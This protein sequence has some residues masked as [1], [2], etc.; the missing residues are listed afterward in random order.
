MRNI[1]NPR[2][3]AARSLDVFVPLILSLGLL[4][5]AAAQTEIPAGADLWQ[6]VG[7]GG[8]TFQDF[9][10]SPIPADF[11]GDGSEA[12]DGT[13]ELIGLP[14]AENPGL[15]PE[16]VDLG[17]ADT[18]VERL[19][20]VV[21]DS[22]GG[23]GATTIQIAALSLHSIEPITVNVNGEPTQWNVEVQLSNQ[24]QQQG[25][26]TITLEDEF[27]GTFNSNLPVLPMFIFVNN[28]NPSD[29]KI[30][31][32]G[33]D[34]GEPIMFLTINGHWLING[35][36][37][38][39]L[40]QPTSTINLVNGVSVPPPV[41]FFPGLALNPFGS[42]KWVLTTEEAQLAQHGVF[43]ARFM[44][45]EDFDGDGI[46]DDCDN[47]PI[48]ANPLQEDEDDDCIGDACDNCPT[49]ANFD[50]ADLDADG[51]GSVCD[52]E[53]LDPNSS[54]PAGSD[55]WSTPDG[56]QTF[57]DF[58]DNPIPADFFGEGSEPF[59]GIIELG[60]SPL[61]ATNLGTGDTVVER[62][63]DATL[64]GP[65]SSDTVPIEM[66]ALSLVSINPITVVIDGEDTQWDVAVSLSDQPQQQGTITIN[67]VDEHGGTFDA[68]LP[69]LPRFTFTRNGS[70]PV[71]LDLGDQDPIVLITQNG[72]F[73]FDNLNCETVGLD[74]ALTLP[75]GT[76]IEGTTDN[77]H[78]SLTLD[79]VGQCKWV[80]TTEEAQLAR[81]GVFPARFQI[82]T[83]ED[84]DSIA[85]DC[86]NCPKVA[87]PLQ[88][89]EDE[90]CVGDACDNC[91]DVYN[92][93]QANADGDVEGDACDNCPNDPDKTSPGVCGC[94]VADDDTDGD[95]TEDCN[96]ECPDDPDKT[97]EGDCGCGESD[98]DTD[99][100]TIADCR[101]NCPDTANTDQADDDGDGEGNACEPDTGGDGP[102]FCFPNAS[103][104]TLLTVALMAGLALIQRRRYR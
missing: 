90:D 52:D 17:L 35:S 57:Q 5:S 77:F 8:Q 32:L 4:S 55:L 11:F 18:L 69:V 67:Q 58:A 47:C 93:D 14:F 73:L 70:D 98:A 33:A 44:V 101:D 59:D 72:H 2:K 64:D 1:V 95:G 19:Q 80:L 56:G 27:G 99:G 65:G 75:N 89:D 9:S 41:G 63:D 54:I 66:K 82:G 38:S 26:M 25:Q 6:T 30:L 79:P 88:E 16:G 104:A 49:D 24:P 68:E 13:I 34:G 78:V 94:G 37:C 39:Q 21:I 28:S 43:P 102:V 100:D 3:G 92:P 45:G 96:D 60:G 76:T 48:T 20:D 23:T 71:T 42:C 62:L 87:N 84:D 12:F 86:D 7:A 83:D 61:D 103:Q 91:R 46:S 29:I 22:A 10:E 40:V 74:D 85:D 51:I 81:H 31:D 97:E 50:Q 36:L 15:A 53:E